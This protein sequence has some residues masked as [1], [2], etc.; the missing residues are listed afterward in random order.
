M[1]LIFIHGAPGAGKLT[2][3]CEL[4]SR[5]DGR[6]FDNHAAIEVA[7]TVFD[8]DAPG[9]WQLVHTV[10][11]AVLT[12]AMRERV[13]LLVMTFV[14]VEPDDLMAF[15]E[16][17]TIVLRYGGQLLSVFLQCSTDE[18]ARRIGNADRV[19]RRKMAS[20]E[21]IRT[22]MAQHRVGAVPRTTC[23]LLDSE[24]ND[25]GTNANYIIGHFKI[26]AS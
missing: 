13:P 24:A 25:A 11:V 3:A 12:A 14:Y 8:F 9:F 4:L 17:E 7:R 20:E 5:V 18:I 1:K 23:L 6:L 26:G 2:T 16:F 10:R 19:S 15:E 21:S 22:F